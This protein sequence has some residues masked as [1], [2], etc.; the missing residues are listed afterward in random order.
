MSSM[1]K[2]IFLIL[3]IL[4]GV[5][6]VVGQV[7]DALTGDARPVSLESVLEEIIQ[8]K[9]IHIVFESAL[10]HDRYVSHAVNFDQDAQNVL[11]DALRRQPIGFERLDPFNFVLIRKPMQ[12]AWSDQSPDPRW[13]SKQSTEEALSLD[14]TIQG[15]VIDAA[16]GEGLIGVSITVKDFPGLGSVTDIDGSYTIVV[17]DSVKVLIF[18]YIGYET[19]EILIGSGRTDRVAMRLGVNQ[20]DEVVITAVGIEANKRALG[21]SIS[22]LNSQDIQ[23]ANEAN[24]VS[25][26]SGKTAGV[27]ITSASGSPG[28]SANIRIRGNKSINGSNQPLIIVDGLP[29][30]NTSSGN[31]SVGVD[32]SNRAIDINPNDIESVSVLKGPAATAM[33]GIRAANGALVITTKKGKEGKPV[34]NLRSSYG[35]STINKS[36]D[37][38]FTYAQGTYSGGA[39]VYR[40]PETG[41]ANSFGPSMS[42]LEYDGD[43]NYLYDRH[44]K[45]VPAGAGTGL[46]AIT[47]DPEADFFD[48]GT[49]ADNNIS[50]SGGNERLRYY[51]SLGA[52]QQQ[53]STYLHLVALFI[54]RQF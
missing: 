9:S 33:Y 7:A 29:I 40:G 12:K 16:S 8:R 42:D 30:D 37:R 10:V 54:Q 45:L 39:A 14:Q 51:T 1:R 24:L 38:Q 20:L 32:V 28:S 52:L 36:F 17:P 19:Q 18:S 35:I 41:E 3:T 23:N 21:Y 2:S 53:G 27:L 15:M 5:W 13:K 49:T 46:R 48:Q 44:G 4:T 31:G 47:Y 22:E 6:P 25:A 43:A 34:I 11:S 26:L 50:V